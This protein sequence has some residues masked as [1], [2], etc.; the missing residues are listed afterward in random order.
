MSDKTVADLP[1]ENAHEAQ[2]MDQL[3][4]E[5]PAYGSVEADAFLARSARAWRDRAGRERTDHLRPPGYIWVGTGWM[6]RKLAFEGLRE[7]ESYSTANP[8]IGRIREKLL[9]PPEA[10]GQR[11]PVCRDPR[12]M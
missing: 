7:W 10:W 1:V 11:G 2:G 8:G 4:E 12:V 6:H 5:I 3:V 9:T